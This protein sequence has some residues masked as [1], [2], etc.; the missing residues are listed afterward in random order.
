MTNEEFN[1]KKAIVVIRNYLEAYNLTD[2]EILEKYEIAV[3]QL[4]KNSEKLEKV[5]NSTVGIKSQTQRDRSTTFADGVEAWTI[6]DD[7]KALLP[8]PNNFYR[9]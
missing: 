5:K 1:Q 4:I 7:I 9:W 6:T 3:L 2:D 8:T